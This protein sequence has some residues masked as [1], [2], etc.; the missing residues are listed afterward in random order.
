MQIANSTQAQKVQRV[1]VTNST[2][3]KNST[4][5]KNSTVDKKQHACKILRAVL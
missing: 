4:M 2:I 5:L 3:I 1:A